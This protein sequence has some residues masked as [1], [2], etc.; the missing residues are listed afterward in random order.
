MSMARLIVVPH[1]FPPP[2]WPCVI[3]HG[4]ILP[5]DS[6]SWNLGSVL[7]A[8][9]F[10][11]CLCITAESALLVPSSGTPRGR[12]ASDRSRHNQ[13][14]AWPTRNRLT[15]PRRRDLRH[16]SV[17]LFASRSPRTAC[18]KQWHTISRPS[19]RS[20]G[21]RRA[22]RS[23]RCGRCSLRIARHAAKPF[24]NSSGSLRHGLQLL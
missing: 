20:W 8:A 14:R 23:L 12:R 7:L 24:H 10:A 1:L 5:R 3:H 15:F 19:Q 4:S 2:D 9:T 11:S 22:R 17:P 6:P 21:T 13:S 16:T 18:S